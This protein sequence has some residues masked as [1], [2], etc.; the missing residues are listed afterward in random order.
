[1]PIAQELSLPEPKLAKVQHPR[2]TKPAGF[3]GAKPKSPR[4]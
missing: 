3:A 2:P 1:V 4:R